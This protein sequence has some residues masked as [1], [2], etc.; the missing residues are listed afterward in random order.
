VVK[1]N[2]HLKPKPESAAWWVSNSRK[3]SIL[4]VGA[5]V[6]A[7]WAAYQNSFRAPFIFDDARA[8]LSNGTIRHFS[9]VLVPPMHST[10]DGR[11][12]LNL[13]LAVNYAWG[14]IHVWGY[15]LVNLA[16][17][18]FA[19][20]TLWGII[21]RTL[22]QP[23]LRE[24]FGAA[25]L[26]LAT[27]AAL[28]WVLHP[29]Q[30]ESVTYVIQRAE[31]LAGLFYLLMLYCFVRSTD[32]TGQRRE[33]RGERSEKETQNPQATLPLS[34][35]LAP[36]ASRLW[37]AASILACLLG[38]ATKEVL[39]SAPL[40]V[41]IYDR[42][43]VAGSFRKAWQ[44]RR[45]FYAGL[46][47]T[48]V[49]LAYLILSSGSRNGSAG[50]G[51]NIRWWA[52]ALTQSW[53][54]VHYLWLSVW[55]CP[56]ILDYGPGLVKDLGTIVPCLLLLMALLAAGGCALDRKP[57]LGFIAAWF[58]FI[59]APTSSIVPIV[60]QTVA[61]H[62]MYL[63]LAAIMTLAVVGLY[64]W[65]GRLALGLG[66]A[67]A[68][69]FGWLTFQR[70]SV[71]SS[72]VSI[73]SDTVAKRPDNARAHANLGAA[74]SDD[75]RMTEALAQ[76]EQ[77]VRTQPDDATIHLTFGITLAKIGRLTEAVAQ[78]EEAVRLKPNF[79]DGQTNL[80]AALAGL[81]RISEALEHCQT[82]VQLEPENA[83][84]HY[85]L[86][87][88]FLGMEHYAESI[89]QY[90]DALRLKPDFA[91]AHNSLGI[92]FVR[93]ERLPEAF[94]QFQEAVR[95]QPNNAVAQLY[96]A[97]GLFQMGRPAEAIGH[98][99][100]ALRLKPDDP[101]AHY[102]LGNALTQ[103]NQFPQAVEQYQEAL[104]LKPDFPEAH[105]N[106]GMTLAQLGRTKEAI[107]QYQ[108]AL[109]LQ[110]DYPQARDNLAGAQGQP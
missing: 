81:G 43:F 101:A 4:A 40:M 92:A 94:N 78:Y 59:L 73:W 57:V 88:V 63:P 108:E 49:L 33:A 2:T 30:T 106:L 103:T 18:I 80:G 64:A 5:I 48:W 65:V 38:M 11:P 67:V 61:E 60:T 47:A 70:N 62:R 99:Q 12:I 93:T 52:Y 17:H 75:N 107:E 69:G 35:G 1:K 97:D 82:A 84:L 23:A 105:N 24:K 83:E 58:F 3:A 10:V 14:G 56:L 25:A 42:T 98:Y 13:S 46:A 76:F 27:V 21:R 37:Q 50:F 90:E 86:G 91:D 104:R 22:G 39:V 44:Q 54:I 9:S 68:V 29:L 87:N 31:S 66:L 89:S 28:L 34:S 32:E 95:L 36:L 102:M 74:L 96:L 26:P 6:L 77:A 53:A 8:I 45:G 16:I 15:H 85:N 19:G 71:Y 100:E 55:P 7:T 41:W 20:L 109:R 72:A 51:L 79:V 110:P